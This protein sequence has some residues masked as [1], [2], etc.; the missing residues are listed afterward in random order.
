MLKESLRLS[1]G[2]VTPLERVVGPQGATIAGVQVPGGVSMLPA[3][4][5]F[6]MIAPNITCSAF[7]TVVAMG[8]TFMHTNQDIFPDPF[9]FNPDRWLQGEKSVTLDKYLISFSKGPRMCLGITY[10]SFSSF[11][12]S[13]HLCSSLA[14]VELYLI[15]GN[16][17]RKLDLTAEGTL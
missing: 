3:L 7:Q 14:W 8:H 16:I 15:M 1:W 13:D 6:S 2:L 11:S 10:A 12:G 17:F 9:R 5:T 4:E